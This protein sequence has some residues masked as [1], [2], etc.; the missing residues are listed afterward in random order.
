MSVCVGYFIALCMFNPYIDAT[1]HKFHL[2]VQTVVYLLF[3]A[4]WAFYNFDVDA[5]TQRD[6]TIMGVTLIC[7]CISFF[8]VFFYY[9]YKMANKIVREWWRKRCLRKGNTQS[10]AHIIDDGLSGSESDDD[11]DEEEDEEAAEE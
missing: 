7:L 11:E 10:D 5:F 9:G 8:V 3:M 2:F 4:G 1:D 6:D